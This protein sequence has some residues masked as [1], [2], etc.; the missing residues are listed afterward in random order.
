MPGKDTEKMTQKIEFAVKALI[1]ASF[2]ELC[3]EYGISHTTGYK[4]RE[5]FVAE[6][7]LAFFKARVKWLYGFTLPK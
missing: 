5:R 2:T 6:E 3:R 1:A 7:N 4:W